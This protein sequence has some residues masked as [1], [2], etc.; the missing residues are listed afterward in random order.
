[1]A[2]YEFAQPVAT[3]AKRL[4]RDFH[5]RL[6]GQRVDY[7][8]LVEEPKKGA[9]EWWADLKIVTGLNAYLA[10]SEEDGMPEPFF[11]LIVKKHIWNRLDEHQQEALID[12]HLC[13]AEYDE[14]GKPRKR[15]WGIN[16]YRENVERYGPWHDGLKEFLEVGA[17]ALLP[18]ETPVSSKD[19]RRGGRLLKVASAPETPPA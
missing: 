14:H 6:D 11:V 19:S 9:R 3:A 13:R 8:F 1:M 15:E 12:E 7:L 16:G 18:L 4:I 10:D 5:D 2:V 17:Q